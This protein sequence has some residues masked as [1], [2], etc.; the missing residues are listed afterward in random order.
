M[1]RQVLLLLAVS[2]CLVA[3][4]ARAEWLAVGSGT[5]GADVRIIEQSRSRTV[6]EVTLPGLEMERTEVA[7]DEYARLSIPGDVMATIEVGKPQVPKVSLLLAVPNGASV[8]ARATVSGTE[9]FSVGNVYPLQPPQVDSRPQPP[10]TIDAGFYA[11]DGSFPGPAVSLIETGVWRDLAVANLQVYPVQVNPARGEITVARSVRVEVSHPG[12]SGFPASVPDWLYPTYGSFID[13]FA[14]LKFQPR[15]DYDEGVRYLVFCHQNHAGNSMLHDSLL[16]WVKQRG[17]ETRVITKSSFTAAEIKDSIRAEYNRHNPPVLQHALLVGEYAEV[18]MGSYSGVGKSDF[19]YIDIEPSPTGDNYPEL[20]TARLSPSSQADLDNQIRKILKYQL[21]PVLTGGWLERMTF[22]AH[23]EQ[24]PA[25]YSGCVRGVYHMPKPYWQPE[26]DT[27]MGQ[28]KNNTDVATAVNAGVGI[29]AYRGHGNTTV[30]DGWCGTSWTNSNVD[31]LTN[32]DMTPVTLHWACYCGDISSATC[33]A[34]AWMRKYPGGSVSALAATQASYTLPNHGQCSTLARAMTDTWTITVPGVRDYVGPVFSVGGQMSYMAAY[35][36]KYWPGS[37]YY[38]NIWMYLTLGEPAMPIW[39]GTPAVPVVTYPDSIP[40]GAYNL[41]VGV[42][43]GGQPVEDALVCAWKDGDFYVVGRTDASGSAMLAVSASSPGEVKITV[44][45]GHARHSTPGV[46]HTPIIPHEGRTM[47]GGGGVQEPNVRYVGNRVDDSGGNNNGRFDP[48]E[49]ADIIVTVRNIGN[50]PAQNLTGKLRAYHAQFNVTDSTSAFGTLAQGADTN[51]AHDRF[52]AVAGND[53]P[54]GTMVQC[55]LYLQ[56]DN[57]GAW[58]YG[59]QLVVGQPP[60]P[61]MLLM[62]HDTGYCRL[63]VSAQGSIGYDV[64]PGDAGSGFQ[65]PKTAASALFYGSFAVGN[66]EGYVADRHFGQPASGP[67]NSDL[68]VVD[69]LRAVVPPLAGDQHYRG[70]YSDAGH[71]SPKG[72]RITQNSYQAAHAGYDDFV[73][74]VFDIANEGANAVNG[75]Y[76]GVFADFDVGANPATNTATSD[77]SRRFTYMRQSASANPTVGV[78]ILEPASFANLTA[79]DHDRYVYPDSAMTDGMKWRLLNGTIVQ[80]NSNR[81][82]DWSTLTSV[83][84]FDLAASES[85][86]FAVAFVG[87]TSED[88]AR[89]HADSAQ[90]WY[91]GNV[92]L[93]EPETRLATGLRP[94][95]LSPNP[96]RRGTYVHYHSALAGR[97]ELVAYDAAGRELERVGFDVAQGGGRYFWQPKELARGVYFLRVSIPGSESVAKILML[98]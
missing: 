49:T 44:S 38:Y 32:G 73:V 87:G 20:N 74:I 79:V 57:W 45:E 88:Q 25:K 54:G 75:L 12:G 2:V 60:T 30:W 1:S 85:Y 67:Q 94:V 48:G 18:P 61:G 55:S 56:S 95:F 28:F 86:R 31:A 5:G 43:A 41:N 50:A 29:L 3:G 21:D 77:E 16:G 17:Y 19:Y 36:A 89:A 96:F 15:V 23:R 76:A 82:Y 71:P 34:E 84:P 52:T 69:S 47:A 72:L 10:F 33:H 26:L 66:A 14:E 97:A 63:T 4:S 9:T 46:P 35:I 83:G 92:G 59:F 90:S 24:Y 8:T 64:A 37:P 93:Q 91:A 53:I 65:Y 78:K 58:K 70:S 51:N 42:N 13:N 98:D 22:V 62:N 40:T 81:A 27:I 6:V 39:A 68:R 7:G 80:R 11:E